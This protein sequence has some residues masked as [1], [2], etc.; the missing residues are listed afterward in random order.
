M[1]TQNAAKC[2]KKRKLR[3]C[4]RQHEP[5]KLPEKLLIVAE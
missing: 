3:C 5:K 2:R 4:L 1:T